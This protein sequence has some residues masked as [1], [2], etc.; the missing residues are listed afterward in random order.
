[1]LGVLVWQQKLVYQGKILEDERTLKSYNI[2]SGEDSTIHVIC[3]VPFVLTSGKILLF[4]KTLTGYT[5][6]LNVYQTDSVQT[7]KQQIQHEYG[8]TNKHK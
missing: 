4:V 5:I 1:L 6:T 7:I 8:K 3:P 2:E